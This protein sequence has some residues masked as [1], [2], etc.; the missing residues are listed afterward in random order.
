MYRILYNS[1]SWKLATKLRFY[2][3]KIKK[4]KLILQ[5]ITSSFFWVRASL[6]SSDMSGLKTTIVSYCRSPGGHWGSS[7][8]SKAVMPDPGWDGGSSSEPSPPSK[9]EPEK[10]NVWTF[11]VKVVGLSLLSEVIDFG[12]V[13]I[14]L[15][16]WVNE[17]G[18][19]G[20]WVRRWGKTG[21]WLEERLESWR[22]HL[23]LFLM[24][25]VSSAEV[26]WWVK[27]QK[28]KDKEGGLIRGSGGPY[29]LLFG[30]AWPY[31][32]IYYL[33]F[34]THCLF[35][36]VYKRKWREKNSIKRVLFLGILFIYRFHGRK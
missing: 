26:Q 28:E 1:Q 16:L 15:R 22:W 27:E 32:A 17:R 14:G 5:N 30:W 21:I 19:G 24:W 18:I 12:F 34:L 9:N 29:P 6:S 13:G 2:K 4:K 23:A 25:A 33:F 8:S 11:T 3:R 10:S 35:A 20:N 7:L 36:L 31:L